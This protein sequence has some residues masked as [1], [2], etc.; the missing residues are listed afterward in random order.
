MVEGIE[1][2]HLLF[3]GL[4][5]AGPRCAWPHDAARHDDGVKPGVII[6][7]DQDKPLLPLQE[8]PHIKT[9]HCTGIELPRSANHAILIAVRKS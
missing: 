7:K 8:D 2:P 4:E 5:Q 9:S 3:A 1:R 6:E